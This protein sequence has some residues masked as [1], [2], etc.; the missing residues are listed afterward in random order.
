MKAHRK[1]YAEN[2]SAIGLLKFNMDSCLKKI[3]DFSKMELAFQET[4]NF[5]ATVLPLRIQN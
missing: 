2:N 1:Q 4:E 3:V 5:L